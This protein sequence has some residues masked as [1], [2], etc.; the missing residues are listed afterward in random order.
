M[1]LLSPVGKVWLGG[2][3]VVGVVGVPSP[4]AQPTPSLF[5]CPAKNART[6]RSLAAA[7]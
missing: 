1:L 4:E 5:L 3:V 6:S 2:G 7:V